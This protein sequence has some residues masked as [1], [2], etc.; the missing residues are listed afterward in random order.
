MGFRISGP[1]HT[2]GDR[3]VSHPEEDEGLP[4]L[5]WFLSGLPETDPADNP[6][7]EREPGSITISLDEA[8]GKYRVT[9]RE[10]KPGLVGFYHLS[11]LRE[12][13][14]DLDDA[15]KLS[16]IDFRV[17]KFARKK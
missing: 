7:A 11:S 3:T 6:V 16:K 9:L 13:F 5:H 15:L 1:A 14:I 10:K 17:D 8:S 4:A 12:L 2:K